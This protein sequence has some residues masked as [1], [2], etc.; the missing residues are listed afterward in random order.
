MQGKM[1]LAVDKNNRKFD[2]ANIFLGEIAL[3]L[4]KKTIFAIKNAVNS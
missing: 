2:V 3:N 4:W 1:S